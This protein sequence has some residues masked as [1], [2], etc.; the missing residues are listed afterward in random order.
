VGGISDLCRGQRRENEVKNSPTS[1]FGGRCY[2]NL[3]SKLRASPQPRARLC[4]VTWSSRNYTLSARMCAGVSRSVASAASY[5]GGSSTLEGRSSRW[6]N[7][8]YVQTA[9]TTS[10]KL[11]QRRHR[12][13]SLSSGSMSGRSAA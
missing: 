2:L 9:V 8:H 3:Q 11:S 7:P 6:S 5:G 10:T 1:R 12:A 4:T 13:S